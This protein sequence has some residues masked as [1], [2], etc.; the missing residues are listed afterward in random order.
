MITDKYAR[1][2][3]LTCPETHDFAATAH[4]KTQ[5]RF[6]QDAEFERLQADITA[7]LQDERQI[8]KRQTEF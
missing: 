4:A 3:D 5:A 2:E 6:C 7:Q 1:F 8:E